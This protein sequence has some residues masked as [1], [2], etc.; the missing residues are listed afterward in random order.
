M[1]LPAH[2]RGKRLWV[3]GLSV[4]LL[5][6][7]AGWYSPGIRQDYF[8]RF[9]AGE[10]IE[11][12]RDI[13][14]IFNKKC[15]ACHGGVKQSGGFSLLFPEEAL[16]VNESGKP[17]IVPSSPSESELIRRIEHDDPDLRMPLE[18]E[19][20]TRE[21]IKLLKKWIRQGAQWQDHWAYIKPDPLDP[22]SLETDWA[23]NGID[24]FVLE[25]LRENRLEPSPEAD[26]ATLLR[27][28][29]LDVIGVPPSPEELQAYLEDTRPDAYEKV[30]DQLLASNQYG[31][32]WAGMW[33]D[34][35]RYADTKGYE[36]DAERKIWKYRDWLIKAFNE[37]MPF[38]VFITKQLAG[39]LLPNPTDEDY[40]ATAFHRNTMTN[41][42]GG[43]ENEEF[44]VAAVIDRVNTTWGILQGTTMECVQCHSH[45]YD[46]IRH[47]DFFKSYAFFNN[48]SDEDVWSESPQLV[49]FVEEED[50][51]KLKAIK[52]W[53]KKKTAAEDT[54][55]IAYYTHL[56]RL[57]EPKIH[58]HSFEILEN[59]VLTDGPNYLNMEDNGLAKLSGITL[60]EEDQMLVRYRSGKT[61]GWIEVRIGA[62]DGPLLTSWKVNSIKTDKGFQTISVPVQPL[63]GKKDLYFVFKDPGHSGT[64]CN[65]EW[66]LFYKAI[67]GKDAAGYQEIT[68]Y[69]VSLLNPQNKIESIP[70]MVER[71][72]GYRRTTYVFERGNWLV[73]GEEVEPG[74]PEDWNSMPPGAPKNR[75]GLAQWLV[76]KDNPLTARVMVNRI[77]AQFFGTGIVETLEDFG[78]QGFEPSHPELLDWLAIEFQTNQQWSLKKLMKM[79]VLSSTY[80]QSSKAS[81]EQIARDPKNRLLARGPR[82]RLNAEQIR[83]QALQVSGLLSKKMYGPSVMPYQPEGLWQVVYNGAN[84]ATS[85]GE[86]QYRRALYTY[87]R[88][89][90]PYP[91]LMSFDSP[92][93]EF[94]VAR[95]IDTNTPIQALV[96]LNDPVYVEA[97]MGL[98]KR[99][100]AVKQPYKGQIS[101]GYKIAMAKTDIDELKLKELES[102]YL[103]TRAY[104]ES[105]P[106]EVEALVCQ[107]D[108]DLA[109]LTVVAN[110]IMNLDEF[111]TKS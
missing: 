5:L 91:S 68:Q 16:A 89:T 104:F 65:L 57:A 111:L 101:Y 46:P 43:T 25:R 33:M 75:L 37:D 105:K 59:G 31:E 47:E 36:R 44:R 61:T 92:S 55:Q 50:Q 74:V 34:L 32:K 58:P 95:R 77:W 71:P 87:W 103:K 41:D 98:A 109:T 53:V 13:R 81:H 66:I 108:I 64:V 23:S 17:A 8:P 97:A 19:P 28:L 26:K 82:V 106:E 51:L 63:T 27:R 3:S 12:N 83:D 11:F 14:P 102:L 73:H 29:Y 35:A 7:L 18:A 79:I 15:I 52:D 107:P 90:N 80:R 6:W 48:T 54:A 21:E 99:M 67:P 88:R 78:S 42:E 24:Q 69:F 40:I 56:V 2:M 30:V 110:V 86:D 70:V 22:P 76:S 9:L 62:A 10:Q 1:N 39:D 4:L 84:W 20:L 60:N 49:S 93:R 100:L 96:T 94:C 85:P 45:P 72:E 38:D